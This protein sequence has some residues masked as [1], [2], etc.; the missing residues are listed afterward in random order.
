MLE[1]M[2]Q[3][4]VYGTEPLKHTNSSTIVLN[5]CIFEKR[6]SGKKNTKVS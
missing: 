1:P 2:E 6:Q 3:C 4:G 5:K